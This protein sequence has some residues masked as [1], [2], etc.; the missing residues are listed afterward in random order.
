MSRY[1][2]HNAFRVVN[3]TASGGT[4]AEQ[5]VYLT[6]D[7]K[8]VSKQTAIH[9]PCC[10]SVDAFGRISSGWLVLW[11]PCCSVTHYGKCCTFSWY[12]TIAN[13][14]RTYAY[15][16]V[17]IMHAPSR[18]TLG[19]RYEILRLN[20]FLWMEFFFAIFMSNAVEC[21]KPTGEGHRCH[22]PFKKQTC[23]HRWNNL[24]S[25]SRHCTRCSFSFCMLSKTKIKTC[26]DYTHLTL[27]YLSLISAKL[28]LSFICKQPGY[29]I[30][31]CFQPCNYHGFVWIDCK[32]S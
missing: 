18:Y 5:K 3:N 32:K 28:L 1:I 2:E 31:L 27:C 19:L 26:S 17:A 25:P 8:C 14:F 12:P 16:C 10:V 7:I 23:K 9:S 22:H 6:Q 20:P 13:W 15:H 4:K 29:S 30:Q 21:V 11:C 24:N